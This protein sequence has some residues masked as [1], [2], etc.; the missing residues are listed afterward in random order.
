MQDN[1]INKII[2]P[3][4]LKKPI[5]AIAKIL[6]GNDILKNCPIKLKIKI[7]DIPIIIDLIIYLIVFIN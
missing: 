3:G 2:K 4:N 7:E 1:T 6:K 5:N